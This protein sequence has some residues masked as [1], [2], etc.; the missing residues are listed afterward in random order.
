MRPPRRTSATSHGPPRPNAGPPSTIYVRLPP[1]ITKWQC[2]RCCA[3]RQPR[4][5]TRSRQPSPRT[6]SPHGPQRR[7]LRQSL[8]R[9]RGRGTDRGRVG[10]RNI[11]IISRSRNA[12]RNR[13]PARSRCDKGADPNAVSRGVESCSRPSA[14]WSACWRVS[15]R[16]P[17]MQ[18]RRTG[19]GLYLLRRGRAA[20]PRHS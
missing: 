14:A 2:S 20:S 7:G 16:R 13:A 17:S 18:T 15:S 1:P 3:D 8:S 9:A 4:A 5:P 19:R 10:V 11:M 12:A 6:C